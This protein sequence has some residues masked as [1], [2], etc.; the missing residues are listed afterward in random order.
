[1]SHTRES[2]ALL[3]TYWCRTASL[4]AD[5]KRWTT[6]AAACRRFA[7]LLLLLSGCAVP[8]PPR[9]GPVD[10]DP[11]TLVRSEPG[12]GEV[13]VSTDRITFRFDED[14]DERSVAQAVSI[15]PEFEVAP[16]INAGGDRIEIVFPEALRPNTTYIVSLDNRLRD[17]HGVALKQP[18]TVAFGTGPSLN[19]GR[20]LGAVVDEARGQ[21]VGGVDV[22]AYAVSDSL[23]HDPHT[24]APD[25]RTQSDDQGRFRFRYLREQPY[26]VLA[27]RDLNGN[28]RLDESEPRGIPA[29]PSVTADSTSSEIET[30]WV[31]SFQDVDPPVI[32]RV[33]ALSSGEL[34]VRFSESIELRDTTTTDWILRD[35]LSGT[36][37]RIV[38]V[39][40]GEDPRDIVLRI[41]SLAIQTHALSGTG[42]VSDSTGNAMLTDTLYFMPSQRAFERILSF[43]EFLPDTLTSDLS[44]Q[45]RIWPGVDAGIRFSSP[46]ADEWDTRV[47]LVDTSG[48]PVSARPF[49][50]DGVRIYLRD[51]SIHNPFDVSVSEADTTYIRRFVRASA[52]VLGELSGVVTFEPSGIP[53]VVELIRD[54]GQNG[55]VRSVSAKED[56]AFRFSELPGGS[57]YRLRYYADVDGNHRWDAGNVLPHRPPEPI[58]WM[59]VEEPVRARWETVVPDTLTIK[60]Y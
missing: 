13:N 39:Y 55:S 30:P 7:V 51:L 47:A 21:G 40:A 59:V 16:T 58:G 49:T 19:E 29:F 18:V 22:F 15:T 60:G 50:R 38:G 25:Y 17:A 33:R 23:T 31:L 57:R 42:A 34:E 5:R 14:L 26:F 28:K 56:G 9:G 43:E 20:I 35:S 11:P 44:N 3:S 53:L 4:G 1:M 36:R 32:R 45:Y 10:E 24:D 37:K 46:P 54:D 12:D 8:I 2:Q 41:D 27:V 48:N 52:A 6:L